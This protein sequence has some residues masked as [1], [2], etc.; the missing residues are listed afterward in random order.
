MC[1]SKV[2]HVFVL[3]GFWAAH[4]SRKVGGVEKVGTGPYVVHH[5]HFFSAS[6]CSQNRSPLHFHFTN[7]VVLGFKWTFFLRPNSTDSTVKFSPQNQSFAK[8]AGHVWVADLLITERDPSRHSLVSTWAHSRKRFHQKFVVT[9]PLG[10]KPECR[11]ST[12]DNGQR[13]TLVLP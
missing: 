7:Y 11:V 6:E 12:K 13:R 4:Q 3:P 10:L 9:V 5:H 1:R 2:P 8:G